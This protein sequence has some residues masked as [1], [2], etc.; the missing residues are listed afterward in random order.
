[1]RSF[2]RKSPQPETRIGQQEESR[3]RSD[4]AVVYASKF[5]WRDGEPVFAFGKCAHRSLR[6][7]AGQDRSYIQW[8]LDPAREFSE[9]VREI[10]REALAGRIRTKAVAP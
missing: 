9:E 1:M 2:E 3:S 4:Y 7:L 6:E 10:L 5:Y 8:M